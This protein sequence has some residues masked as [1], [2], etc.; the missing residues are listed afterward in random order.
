[1]SYLA[2]Y[3]KKYVLNYRTSLLVV[4]SSVIF[5]L[6]F[7]VYLE[8]KAG[9][10]VFAR[11]TYY[12]NANIVQFYIKDTVDNIIN[13]IESERKFLRKIKPNWSETQITVEVKNSLIEQ[14]RNSHY[15]NESYVSVKE[16]WNYSG[17]DDYARRLIHP[18]RTTEGMMLSTSMTDKK[19][20]KFYE[21]ELYGVLNEGAIFQSYYYPKLG[22][23]EITERL[24]YSRLYKDF[25]W[26]IS[27]GVNLD[28]LNVYVDMAKE[29]VRPVIIRN[30]VYFS[31]WI[32]LLI[33]V[34]LLILR[35]F[36]YRYFS[37]KQNIL[38]HQI[39]YDRLTGARSRFYGIKLLGEEY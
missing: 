3:L 10:E 22:S 31:F 20:K 5:V 21:L 2:F 38:Q 24:G 6:I 23:N 39:D 16:I 11:N 8:F 15:S 1:M 29:E 34:S 13:E 35:R 26:I 9:T 19:G 37:L 4:W 28:E 17:G 25:D 12:S 32:A 30:L 33:L 14:L 27:M 18:D 7:L 36:D